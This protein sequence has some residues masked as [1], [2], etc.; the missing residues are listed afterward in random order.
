MHL[1]VSCPNYA[2]EKTGTGK[3]TAEMAEWLASKGHKVQVIT[4]PPHYPEWKLHEGFRNKHSRELRDGVHVRRVPMFIPPPGGVTAK[5]RIRMESSF[6]FHSLGPWLRLLFARRKPD[7]VIAVC[8]PMQVGLTAWLYCSLRRVPWVYHIQDLQVDAAIRLGVLQPKGFTRVLYKL[9]EF[10]LRH[11]TRVSTITPGMR[12]RILEKGVR[13]DRLL[14]FPNWSDVTTM[15][16]GPREN[17]FRTEL[18]L[19]PDDLLLLYAGNMGRKQGLEILIDAARRLQGDPRLHFVLVGDGAARPE[20]A[21]AAQDLPNVLFLPL[22]PWER[23]PEMLNATDIH[24]VIQ[25]R[26]AADLVMPSKLTNILAVGGCSLAT[27][28]SSTT[29]HAVL[30]ENNAG[31]A[32]EPEDT[33]ALVAGL[34]SLVSDP[35]RRKAIGRNARRYAEANL[36]KDA[37]LHRFERDLQALVDRER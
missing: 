20:L 4:G 14:D 18:G 5:R 23:V 22:Q 12:D 19:G 37:I 3:Y 2:P 21:E 11:A 28:G 24:L 16:P 31:L 35:D 9:E 7:V 36:D 13:R 15:R 34:G 6:T 17:S 1:L 33:D 27:A 30:T 26:E 8:P 25:K 32:V 10:F 29:L